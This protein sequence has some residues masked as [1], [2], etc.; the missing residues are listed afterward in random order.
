MAALLCGAVAC[1][2][3]APPDTQ[4]VERSGS[5]ES[6]SSA[7]RVGRL[8]WDGS[9]R[10]IGVLRLDPRLEW[11]MSSSQRGQAQTA[12][13]ILV[14]SDE[15]LLTAGKADIWDSGKVASGESINVPYQGPRLQARQRGAWTVRVWDEQDR[16]S[17]YGK[18]STWDVG[19]WDE[20]VEGDWIGRAAKPGEAAADRESSVS[21]FRRAFSVPAG[22]KQTRLYATAFGLYQVSIN[23]K[24]VTDEVLTPGFTDY[25]KRALL[26]TRDVTAL[27][28]A[29]D[30][31][32]GGVLA[33]GWCTARLFGKVGPCGSEPPRLRVT[34]EVTL[35]NGKLQT[36]ESDDEWKY[37]S[38]PWQSARLLE[39]ES[40][41]ARRE[42]PGWDTPG[43]DDT[44]W[45]EAV[46]YGEHLERNVYPD[47]GAPIR[48]LADQPALGVTEPSPKVYVFDLGRSIAGW[49]RLNIEAAAGTEITLRFARALRSDGTLAPN[50]REPAATDRYIARGGGVESWE[51]RFSVR[52]FRYVE[53]RGLS[54]VPSANA[55]TGRVVGSEMARTGSLRT[56]DESINQLFDRVLEAQQDSFLSVPSLSADAPRMGSTLEAQLFAFTSCL[57]RDTQRFYRKWIDDLRDAQLP[58]AAY[59]DAAPLHAGRAGGAIAGT[60][61]ILVPWALHRCYA[62]RAQ[63]DEHTTSMGRFLDLIQAK[64]PSLIWRNETGLD[65]GDPLESGATTDHAL[66]ATAELAHAADALAQMLRA[67]TATSESERYAKLAEDTRAAFRA[68]F[69]LPDGRLKSDTQTAYAVAIAR[70][71]LEGQDRD[72]AGERLVEALERSQH[73]PT[74]GVLGSALLLPA[75]SRIGRDDLAYAVLRRFAGADGVKPFDIP[76]WA[77]GEWMYDAIGGIALDPAAP[78]GRRVLVR[79]R[80]G[81]GLTSARASFVS[82]YGLV[83]TEWKLDGRSFSIKVKVPV[84]STAGV[85]LP[86]VTTITEAGQPVEKSA[87]VKLIAGRPNELE[88][89]SGTYELDAT[90]R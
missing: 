54:S 11:Q 50:E 78:A 17:P 32:I 89:E 70:G 71:A 6:Q 1:N 83:E 21:Y 37:S 67:S 7:L 49:A 87:G 76:L 72:R 56:S 65:L 27:V 29:G 30:N 28:R 46:E 33:G 79:P 12:Y 18:P 26:Q 39:G 5:P 16:P 73:Q 53:V 4:P 66:L 9:E 38:G 60:A 86:F 19:P 13:Q 84:G 47:R 88:L 48:V 44:G 3:G 69:L 2:K 34:L 59:G 25:E 36:L 90:L 31:V 74:T 40:Y 57:N 41:D 15:Q 10:P 82:L 68:E 23:G 8:R 64:N 42:M 77:L 81:A 52:R 61:G 55:V 45:R 20:E 58:N 14:A 63:I 85:S 62:D 24:P 80:P 51:P 22:F 35:P 43:F 75:L